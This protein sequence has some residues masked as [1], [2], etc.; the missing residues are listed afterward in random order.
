M[1]W[2]SFP[3]RFFL[4]LGLTALTVSTAG[5]I[6]A[7]HPREGAVPAQGATAVALAARD[8]GGGVV[9]YGY[10]D[11]EGGVTPLAPLQPGRVAEVAVHENDTV[12]A[13]QVLFRMDSTLAE[14]RLLEAKAALAAAE[15]QLRQAEVLPEQ[16]QAQLAQQKAAIEAAKQRALAAD[17]VRKR[18]EQLVK[19]SQTNPLDLQAAEK[20][21][22]EAEAG[23]RAE[24]EKLKQLS[25]VDPQWRIAAAKADVDAKRAAVEQAQFALNECAVRAPEDG[26]ILQVQVNPGGLV[27]GRSPQPA[28]LFV[29]AKPRIVRAEVEQEFADRVSVNQTVVVHDEARRDRTWNGKVKRISDWYTQRRSSSPDTLRISNNDVH[30]LECIIALDAKQSPLRMGQRVRVSIGKN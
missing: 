1:K 10:V 27:T 12:K 29:A 23:A 16:H 22:K 7:L 4:L 8:S 20:L 3:M 2:T 9:C 13:K 25:L 15:A 19:S 28:M 26:E 17:D 14:Q 18:K 5:A 6:F 30:V 21:V 24:E 11:V